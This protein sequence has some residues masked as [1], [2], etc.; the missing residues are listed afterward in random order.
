MKQYQ[1]SI[2]SNDIVVFYVADISKYDYDNLLDYI[3]YEAPHHVVTNNRSPLSLKLELAAHALLYNLHIARERTRDCD[4][5]YPQAWYIRAGY[6]ICG[7]IG[8]IFNK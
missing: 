8:L 2:Y 1:I 3:Y 4:L 7:T 6:A 5:N